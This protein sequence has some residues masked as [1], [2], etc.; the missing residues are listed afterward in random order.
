MENMMIGGMCKIHTPSASGLGF[1][2]I[3]RR[4]SVEYC[5][6]FTN[7][8]LIGLDELN[9]GNQIQCEMNS[10]TISVPVDLHNFTCPLLGVTFV[11]V[12]Q[13]RRAE[14]EDKGGVFMLIASS[15][16]DLVVGATVR[17]AGCSI[18]GG[19]QSVANTSVVDELWGF[20]CFLK[21]SADCGSIGS[22]VADESGTIVG[23]LKRK[24]DETQCN[25]AVQMFYVA[26][27][28]S[29]HGARMLSKDGASGSST[30]SEERIEELAQEGLI[31][32]DDNLFVSPASFGITPI[33][34][35]RSCHSWFWT[36]NP[37][38]SGKYPNWMRIS[39][40]DD[41]RVIGGFWHG[42]VPATKNTRIIDFLKANG[43]IYLC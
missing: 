12:N 39:S 23:M 13:T 28:I 14:I 2:G 9:S 1:F 32:V 34:F 7:A 16:S 17:V 5:G 20:E 30:L 27:A 25:V 3:I 41:M 38:E 24:C 21:G 36:P 6:L 10:E 11:Q 29:K 15:K 43:D 42:E 31:V 37:V 22:L 35:R 33:W 26:D 8:S 19:E 4:P 40:D 18:D